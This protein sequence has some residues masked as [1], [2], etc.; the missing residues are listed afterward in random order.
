MATKHKNGQPSEERQRHN[1]IAAEISR[2]LVANEWNIGDRLPSY[3]K[4]ASE[5]KVSIGTIQN[6]IKL[7]RSDG[8]VDVHP[9]RHIKAALGAQ[10]STIIKGA[11]AVVL[12]RSTTPDTQMLGGL[13]ARN[14][15]IGSA[16]VLLNHG[17]WKI[18][19][20]SGFRELPVK[21]IF[22]VG[23]LK[24]QLL[25]QYSSLNVPVILLDQPGDDYN[26]HSISV[27]NF[28][29][30]HEATTRLIRLGHQRI[31]F[32]R[33]IVPSLQ[34]LDPDS[35][36]R[37][38]GFVAACRD[39]GIQEPGFATYT[40]S[41]IQGGTQVEAT[42]VLQA[43]PRFT[44]LL[45][46]NET[47]ATHVEAIA[48][49]MRLRIPQDLSIA[50]FRSTAPTTVNWSGPCIDFS[51]LG[52]LALDLLEQRPTALQHIRVR[53]AWHAGATTARAP[54]STLRKID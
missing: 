24:K 17:Q 46:A 50:T 14:Y 6:A 11:I 30:A 7:L 3:R 45:I 2:R 5:F 34:D 9:R 12:P 15:R 22:L 52:R 8:W 54:H 32:L 40:A 16:I 48:K 43:I 26:L 4:L 33:Y 42:K 29:A 53:P 10:I 31:A 39:A 47:Q 19:F 13:L 20:P 51:E 27:A 23:P 38:A 28:D 44:A 25:R 41:N 21:G 49:S 36:E 35:K 18:R 1:V 37:Q